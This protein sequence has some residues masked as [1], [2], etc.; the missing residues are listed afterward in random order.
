MKV[1]DTYN[2]IKEG[3][4]EEAMDTL[5]SEMDSVEKSVEADHVGKKEELKAEEGK[6]NIEAPK[7]EVAEVEKD[8]EKDNAACGEEVSEVVVKEGEGDMPEATEEKKP[9][10]ACP[11]ETGKEVEKSIEADHAEDKPEQPEPVIVKEGEG[12]MP[13]A[14]EEKKPEEACPVE[15]GKEAEKDLEADHAEVKD[16]VEEVVV[17]EEESAAE[18][19]EDAIEKETVHKEEDLEPVDIK[20]DSVSEDNLETNPEENKEVELH[21]GLKPEATPE[22]EL[23][24]AEPELEPELEPEV[25]DELERQEELD[26]PE[27]DAVEKEVFED[28]PEE[29]ADPSLL[30]LYNLIDKI[31]DDFEKLS[32]DGV[33]ASLEADHA[34]EEKDLKPA[35]GKENEEAPK[36]EVTAV[37][38]SLEDDHAACG[39]EVSEVVV[40]ECDEQTKKE[41]DV[42]A[43][44]ASEEGA[45]MGTKENEKHIEDEKCDCKEGDCEKPEAL[46]EEEDPIAKQIKHLEEVER[47]ITNNGTYYTDAINDQVSKIEDQIKELREKQ[48]KELTE[49][50][51][52]VEEEPTEDDLKAIEAGNKHVGEVASGHADVD[53]AGH[54]K[55]SVKYKS[56]KEAYLLGKDYFEAETVITE[57]SEE[58]IAK[59]QEQLAMLAAREANDAL[60]EAVVSHAAALKNLKEAIVAK[61]SDS[62]ATITETIINK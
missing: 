12:D 48:K 45:E 46:K 16:D 26:K 23:E 57:S 2:L 27:E 1:K 21:T 54:I 58:K 11:V 62:V 56:L 29:A 10:E 14:T 19:V 20:E 40:K 52:P 28:T 24:P 25:K 22:P 38:K 55:K 9:E 35:E 61:Y 18:A 50:K 37:E 59:L 32:E 36:A 60:Y 47:N 51:K 7:A 13:E 39:E 42:D 6:E 33:E 3:K 31:N 4:V 53:E 17:K 34:A 41:F 43:T 15:T 44:I 5:L 30:E 8:L 49:A